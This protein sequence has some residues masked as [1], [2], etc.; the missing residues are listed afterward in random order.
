MEEFLALFFWQFV[1]SRNTAQSL[2]G[3]PLETRGSTYVNQ[4]PYDTGVVVKAERSA[5]AEDI[6]IGT[7]MSEM[8]LFGSYRMNVLTIRRTPCFGALETRGYSDYPRISIYPPPWSFGIP[9]I[10]CGA[11]KEHCRMIPMD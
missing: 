11:M 7:I 4:K 1:S 5:I 10:L 8:S 9:I 6:A 2:L 3:I